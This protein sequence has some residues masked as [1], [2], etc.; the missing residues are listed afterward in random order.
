MKS[1]SPKWELK[2]L[3]WTTAVK[4]SFCGS[5]E[6]DWL[7]PLLF[8]SSPPELYCF[9]NWSNSIKSSYPDKGNSLCT[10]IYKSDFRRTRFGIFKI[11]VFSH[12]MHYL[13][14][15]VTLCSP[16]PG[17]VKRSTWMDTSP[18]LPSSR[19]RISEIWPQANFQN[20]QKVVINEEFVDNTLKVSMQKNEHS[21]IVNILDSSTFSKCQNQSNQSYKLCNKLLEK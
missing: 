6:R 17:C 21:N 13:P 18:T 4:I 14:L 9:M 3:S 20:M 2:K 10:G 1:R 5:K 11:P 19:L 7:A 12:I 8:L 15:T 16:V